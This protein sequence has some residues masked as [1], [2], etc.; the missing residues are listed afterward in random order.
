M[1]ITQFSISNRNKNNTIIS[2]QVAS[3]FQSRIYHIEPISMKATIAFSITLHW[4]NQLVA[5]FI[6]GSTG[7]FEVFARLCEIVIIDEVITCIIWRVYVNHL[8]C[9][10]IVLTENL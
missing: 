10:E 8:D 2:E 9:S 4:V 5:I 6:E 1:E 3:D 7:C